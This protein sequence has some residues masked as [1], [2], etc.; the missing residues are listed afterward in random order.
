MLISKYI[1]ENKERYLSFWIDMCKLEGNSAD[2][3]SVNAVV[4]C[5]ERFAVSEGFSA[6]RY[7]FDKA[8][9]Y[10]VI[11]ANKDGEKGYAYIAHSDTVFDKGAFGENPVKVSDDKI[12]GPG[13]IDCKGG[14]AVAIL[15][16][17][18]LCEN[19]YKKHLRLIVTSDEEV[20][21]SLAG[22]KGVELIKS[23]SEG[24][25]GAFCCEVG[26]EG[27]ILTSRSG[28]I[29]ITVNVCGKAAHSG[30][31]YFD[32]VNAIGEAAEKIIRI[33]K[34]SEKG[35]I[36]YSCNIINGGERINIV[37]DSCT[38]LA[39]IR[40]KA[41]SDKE[42]VIKS[43]DSIINAD[44]TGGTSSSYHIDSERLPME[45]TDGNIA[46][47]EDIKKVS[48]EFGIEKIEAFSTSGGGSDAAYSV[49]AGVPTVC[50]IG[51]T[52]DFCH[53]VNEYAYISSLEK[54]TELISRVI[55]LRTL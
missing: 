34:L 51:T 18:A 42:K 21:N 7:S 49:A 5:I 2:K 37:P 11:D 45:L 27:E 52:G 6:S 30:I 32:G 29:R 15:S 48:V 1:E 3:E 26:K 24:F 43:L 38:F 20:D 4:D 23:M 33:Q 41:A 25:E 16:M 50:G 40:I 31:A 22:Q 44:F 54:R 8:A 55:L 14:I 17:K 36:T 13:V 19:G 10:L 39:D 35:G 9:D 53:T 28:I 46:L 47:F 12:Y